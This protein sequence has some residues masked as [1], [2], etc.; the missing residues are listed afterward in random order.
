MTVEVNNCPLCGKENHCGIVNGQKDCWCMAVY[1]PEE[2]FQA[3]P[4]ELRK[5][6]CQKCL[7]TYK[8]TK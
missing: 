7:D 8:N 5:C 2:I 3:V 6:I 1:F 4:Q